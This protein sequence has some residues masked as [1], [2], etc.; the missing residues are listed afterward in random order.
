VVVAEDFKNSALTPYFN[1]LRA[2]SGHEIIPPEG[3]M[4]RLFKNLR[5]GGHSSFLCDLTVPPTQAATIIRAFGM[6]MSVTVLHAALAQRTGRPVV[7]MISIPQPDGTYLVRQWAPQYF[8]ATQSLP[9]I[10]QHLWDQLEPVI[11]AAPE[12]W[13]WMYKHWRYRPTDPVEAAVPYPSYANVSKKFSALEA[14]AN[15]AST[16]R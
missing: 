10:A 2:L 13:M 9:D 12:H 1:G 6:K 16:A 7:L 5:R 14:E 4:L 8:T 3:A 15:A 11:R